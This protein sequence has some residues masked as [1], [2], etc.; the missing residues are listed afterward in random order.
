MARDLTKESSESMKLYTFPW[1]RQKLLELCIAVVLAL[2][3]INYSHT[4]EQQRLNDELR[5]KELLPASAWFLVNEVFVPDHEQGSNPLM[6]YDRDVLE[7]FQGFWIV[8][9]QSVRG[10]DLF[11][12]SCPGGFGN[13]YYDPSE[14][15]EDHKVTWTWFIGRTC[16]VPPGE[17]RLKIHYTMKKVGWPEK[18]V[19]VY[20][21][22]FQVL[23]TE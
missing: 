5:Q 14:I 21:N 10:A 15:I 13:S 12:N 9:V 20:S 11:Q 2:S 3:V 1:W 8:E 16:A 7:G 4:S 17:Y 23:P 19:T 18:E 6:I 22:T